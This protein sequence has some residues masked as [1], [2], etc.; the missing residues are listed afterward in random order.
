ML[1]FTGCTHGLSAGEAEELRELRLATAHWKE[2]DI[3]STQRRA[4]G[5]CP[6]TPRETALFLQALGYPADTLVYVANGGMY[7][8]DRRMR[9]FAA[10][11]PNVVSISRQGG[12]RSFLGQISIN[13]EIWRSV[14]EGKARM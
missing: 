10:L 5:R 2:K 14:W 7:G 11:F 1:A 4:E 13:S 8:G 3:N 12:D 9:E 6:L